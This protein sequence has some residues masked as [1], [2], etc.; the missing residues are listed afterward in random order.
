VKRREA[1]IVEKVQ[2]ASP[3]PQI[4]NLELRDVEN[5]IA[6]LSAEQRATLLLV[7]LEGM[8]Y[9]EVAEICDAPIGTVRSRLS[10]ARE[11]L[12]QMIEG[13]VASSGPQLRVTRQGD[14]AAIK[15]KRRSD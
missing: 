13:R 10:R 9:E 1:I 15:V 8:K 14:G 6:R 12:R 4:S 5:A 11:S 2:P 7:G 3:A